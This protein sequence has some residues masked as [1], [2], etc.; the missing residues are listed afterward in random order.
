MASQ[1]SS[2]IRALNTIRGVAALMVALFHAPAAFGVATIL[3]HA[4]VAVDLF[5][6]LSGIVISQAYGPRLDAGMSFGRFVQLRMAR[7]YPLIFL[8]TL[9]GFGL[10]GLRTQVNH[11]GLTEGALLAVPVNLLLLPSPFQV[12]S[13]GEAF[14]YLVQAWSLTWEF[15]MYVGFYVWRRPGERGVW[16]FAA[17]GAV[18]LLAQVAIHGRADGGWTTQTF[19]IGGGRALFGFWA[20]VALGNCRRTV[21]G[22]GLPSCVDRALMVGAGIAAALL[23]Y[24]VG[25]VR[26]DIWWA[27]ALGPIVAVPL[28]LA[29]LILRPQRWLESW[30]GDRL[31]EMSYSIYLL[32]GLTL[33]LLVGGLKRMP[34]LSPVAHF[35]VGLGWLAVLILASWCIWR[36]VEMP[37]RVYFSRTAPSPAQT[38]SV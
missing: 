4:Y 11:A 36:W 15:V 10:W 9:A 26:Q 33:D 23:L 1:T 20:G 28:I 5:F 14:P 13:H 3:P 25:F 2:E 18:A 7:L 21:G 31:G 32:H 37:L 34:H 35:T 12:K 30:L 19:M 22:S 6:V 17:M 24:Y 29:A 8:A 16:G 38:A 27:E